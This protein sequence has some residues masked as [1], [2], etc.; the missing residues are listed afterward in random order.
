MLSQGSFKGFFLLSC[1]FC[2]L[3]TLPLSSFAENDKEQNKELD[4][5]S[6]AIKDKTAKWEAKET[7][8]SK[9]SSK[10]KKDRLEKSLSVITG[11]E[12]TLNV[13]A[14]NLPLAVDWRDYAAGNYV[15]PVKD[16]GACG[17]CWAFA[18]AA[19]LESATLISGNTPGADLDL[20]PQTALS[21]SGAGTCSGGLIDSASDFIRDIGL[22]L[23]SCFPYIFTEGV[24][25]DACTGW[26]STAYKVTDWYRI[27]ASVDAMKYALYNYGPLVATLAVHTDSTTTAGESIP[28]PGAPLR[29]TIP[30]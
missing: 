1:L 13:G 8:V 30:H 4:D 20:S 25:T 11:Q 14:A 16:Q 3:I 24:C 9:L 28:M 23:E 26:Q 15:T 17:S 22:P 21:C 5:V 27:S 7:S 18:A 12:K 19:A 6:Q 10:E 2:F 29:G